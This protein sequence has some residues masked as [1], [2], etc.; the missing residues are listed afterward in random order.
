MNRVWFGLLGAGAV[1]AVACSSDPTGN[2]SG[3]G[4]NGANVLV[5]TAHD[6]HTFTPQ[7][8]TASVGQQICF[9]NL[10]TVVHT[11][12]PDSGVNADSIWFQNYSSSEALPPN[13]PYQITLP[14]GNY[15]YHCHIHGAAGSGMYGTIAVR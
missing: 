13:L 3:C 1:I 12:D 5:I 7:F 10:G 15:N 9:Q 4:G 14:L 2:G 8:A 11:V 6:N